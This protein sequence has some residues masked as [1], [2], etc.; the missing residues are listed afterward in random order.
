MRKRTDLYQKA[1]KFVVYCLTYDAT[2]PKWGK[3][4]DR[5]ML[6]KKLYNIFLKQEKL[7]LTKGKLNKNL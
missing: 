5:S 7:L 1:L 3:G 4:S 2:H 6:T